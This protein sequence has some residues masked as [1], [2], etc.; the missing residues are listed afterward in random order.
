MV[1]VFG[2]G[3]IAKSVLKN[4]E[5]P[6]YRAYQN[7]NLESDLE[8]FDFSSELSA[9][10]TYNITL[11]AGVANIHLYSVTNS[12]DLKIYY[13]YD[14]LIQQADFSLA[15]DPSLDT[16][17]I[18]A[19]LAQTAY[20]KYVDPVLPSVEIYLPDAINIDAI[21]INIATY[22]SLTMQYVEAESLEVDVHHSDVSI[23][24]EKLRIGSIDI[25]QS[26]GELQIDVAET[27]DVT[28]DL[29]GVYGDVSLNKV[30][31]TV[32]LSASNN[33]DIFMYQSIADAYMI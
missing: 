11:D 31:N 27:D 12:T 22:G 28:M 5:S 2:S 33:S 29:S 10:Q 4:Y 30:E 16:I 3:W 20:E 26:N 9:D 1:V 7:I 13:L 15:V 25:K 19:N 23:N 17:V 6:V 18:S 32:W 24:A 8:E 14:T 21:T